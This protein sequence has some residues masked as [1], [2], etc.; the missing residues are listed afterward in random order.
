MGNDLGTTIEKI[1][2]D[3]PCTQEENEEWSLDTHIKKK[4]GRQPY[5]LTKAGNSTS[6]GTEI[7]N[8][9]FIV[10]DVMFSHCCLIGCE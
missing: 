3:Q 4:I 1:P 8:V 9:K 10:I 6:S 7:S 2:G 5:Q